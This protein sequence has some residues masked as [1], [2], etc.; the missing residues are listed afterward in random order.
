MRILLLAALAAPFIA[1]IPSG[2]DP[3]AAE[4]WGKHVDRACTS[5]R[6]GLRLAAAKKVA[7][8]GGAAVPAIR[9]FAQ[10]NGRNAIPQAIVEEIADDAGL[11][12]PVLELLR[13]WTTD[14][15]FYWR[16]SAMRGLALRA[17]K[18][19]N[20]AKDVAGLK[21]LFES[22]RHDA[23]WLMRTHA[24]FGE[25]LLDIAY[26]MPLHESDSRAR[27]RLAALLLEHRAKQDDLPSL[28][29]LI[30]ALADERTFQGD[31]W[32]KRLAD[33]ANKALKIWLG[34]EYP[35]IT[36]GDTEGGVRAI[37]VAAK[38]KSGQ[39]LTVPALQQDPATPFAGGIEILS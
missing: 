10:K 30:D 37:A 36:G 26:E 27:V 16:A 23:A 1:L 22:H 8:G 29:P 34:D 7:G 25:A 6:Y 5:P 11:D 28:Q 4:D 18:L 2:Q 13:E 9:E 20:L 14:R 39:D 38:E 3:A 33:S 12:A 21:E 19:T 35:A 17:P 15:D 31:P 32:G 24:R